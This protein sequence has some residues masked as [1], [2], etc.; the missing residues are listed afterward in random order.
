MHG[1]CTVAVQMQ[2]VSDH[3]GRSIA[4]SQ[5]K[6]LQEYNLQHEVVGHGLNSR[7]RILPVLKAR[8]SVN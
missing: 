6:M 8:L 2:L 3:A 4:A 7:L 1:F 5:I